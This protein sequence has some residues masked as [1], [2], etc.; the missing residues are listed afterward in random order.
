MLPRLIE[1]KGKQYRLR[2]LNDALA[3]YRKRDAAGEAPAVISIDDGY[4]VVEAIF[5][6]E[7][8]EES[9]DNE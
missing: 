8:K 7:E 4:I 5:K 2:L 6:K 3:E 9:D 1:Y